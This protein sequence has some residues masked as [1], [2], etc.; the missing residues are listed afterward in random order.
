MCLL[1]TCVGDVELPEG[2]SASFT[3]LGIRQRCSEVVVIAEG[4]RAVRADPEYLSAELVVVP[5]GVRALDSGAF[6][7]CRV[8][9]RVVFL[10]ERSLVVIGSSCFQGSGLEE[11]A[12]PA[13][14]RMIG[15]GA[16]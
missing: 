9:R 4:P 16:F 12:I 3:G 13:S 11:V 10:D 6:E 1:G 7:G 5:S 8:L 14:V 2:V 15:A